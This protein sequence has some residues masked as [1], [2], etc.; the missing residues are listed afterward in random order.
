MERSQY[1]YIY[2]TEIGQV[3]TVGE[4]SNLKAIMGERQE[5]ERFLSMEGWSQFQYFENK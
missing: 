5:S 3:I 1:D 2:C 4:T